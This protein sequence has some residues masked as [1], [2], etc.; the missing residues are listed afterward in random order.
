VGQR[1]RAKLSLAGRRIKTQF[2]RRVAKIEPAR[3]IAF[4]IE[5]GKTRNRCRDMIANQ[6]VIRR[7]I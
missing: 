4:G 7:Q 1:S 2:C 5:V 6:V 3:L